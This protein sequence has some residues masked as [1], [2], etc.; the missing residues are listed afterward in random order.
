MRAL[1]DRVVFPV[2]LAAIGSVSPPLSV[3]QSQ[4]PS[5][6]TSDLVY[7]V[8]VLNREKSA[9]HVSPLPLS[10][11]RIYQPHPDGVQHVIVTVTERG[12]TVTEYVAEYDSM[13]Y[14]VQGS[15]A[16]DAL[17][18]TRLDSHTAEI[19]L[20][21]GARDIG[22]ARRVISP[23][24]KQMTMTVSVGGSRNIAVYDKRGS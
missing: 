22:V 4:A 8:W 21:H 3:A 13:E 1:L 17:K 18:L 10:V 9:Y 16:I 14:P 11:V 15:A 20:R 5:Q 24:G 2:L 7:G 12:T 6:A 19:V 23:D